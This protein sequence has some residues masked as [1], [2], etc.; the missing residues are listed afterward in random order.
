M[1]RKKLSDAGA[2][3]KRP[4][5]QKKR[6][7]TSR[8]PIV[9]FDRQRLQALGTLLAAPICRYWPRRVH[10]AWG[11]H[12]DQNEQSLDDNARLG[13]IV[14][15]RARQVADA[16]EATF[17]PR[18]ASASL[19]CL[20]AGDGFSTQP[21]DC[22]AGVR[23]SCPKSLCVNMLRRRLRLDQSRPHERSSNPTREPALLVGW[24]ACRL[25]HGHA[26]R[27]LVFRRLL[28]A[29][30]G[31]RARLRPSTGLKRQSRAVR[32]PAGDLG[33]AFCSVTKAIL[34]QPASPA[35]RS[36]LLD[37]SISPN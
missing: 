36:I 11:V 10:M 13:A 27:T 1:P 20:Y 15:C 35:C 17:R 37:W 32:L 19:P 4:A 26:Q 9:G 18:C 22:Q 21:L 12:L 16:L 24:F 33:R 23:R 25:S 29:V 6:R 14:Q 28:S 7:R 8:Q 30:R 2:S 5:I 34:V 3:D 31:Y